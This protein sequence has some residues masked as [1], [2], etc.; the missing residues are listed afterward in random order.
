M[1]ENSRVSKQVR[2]FSDNFPL[3]FEAGSFVWGVLPFQF[4]SSWL[5]EH[6]CVKLIEKS[7]FGWAGFVISSKLRNLKTS[8]KG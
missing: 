6:D 7:L 1:F 4:Y 2:I 5:M 8:T 3:L